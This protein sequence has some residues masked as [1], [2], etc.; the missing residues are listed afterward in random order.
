MTLERIG[1]CQRVAIAIA[2]VN[3][4]EIL[5]VYKIYHL[6]LL[7]IRKSKIQKIENINF[8]KKIWKYQIWKD[9]TRKKFLKNM[10]KIS[11]IW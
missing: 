2:L 4:S 5:I 8:K 6:N 3:K 9:K 10:K 7:K 11:I 1:Q